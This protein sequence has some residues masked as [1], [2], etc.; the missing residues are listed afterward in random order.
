MELEYLNP[1]AGWCRAL[2]LLVARKTDHRTAIFTGMRGNFFKC[3]KL[4]E[5][6]NECS[7]WL[8]F[9]HFFQ[10]C[11][12]GNFNHAVVPW[13]YGVRR[14]EWP[15]NG[16]KDRAMGAFTWSNIKNA[17]TGSNELFL[18][19]WWVDYCIIVG[20]LLPEVVPKM[21]KLIQINHFVKGCELGIYHTLVPLLAFQLLTME[22][23]VLNPSNLFIFIRKS[24]LPQQPA[25]LSAWRSICSRSPWSFWTSSPST[26]RSRSW[27]WNVAALMHV[28]ERESVAKLSRSPNQ[29]L[30]RTSTNPFGPMSVCGLLKHSYEW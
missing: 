27:A 2:R 22:W 1:A 14:S 11:E 13:G 6:I 17:Q 25:S 26:P 5:E 21:F 16:S 19:G 24:Q 4:P 28:H 10:D 8:K 12:L 23:N 30:F 7:N 15:Q 29:A 20:G 18:K 9:K 3:V